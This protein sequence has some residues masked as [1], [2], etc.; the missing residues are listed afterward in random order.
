MA[1][2]CHC[3]FEERLHLEFCATSLFSTVFS[4]NRPNSAVRDIVFNAA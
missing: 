1:N 3:W 2:R 4:V